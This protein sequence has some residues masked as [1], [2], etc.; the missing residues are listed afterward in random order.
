MHNVSCYLY[1]CEGYALHGTELSPRL[2]FLRTGPFFALFILWFQQ[3]CLKIVFILRQNRTER[4]KRSF[5]NGCLFNYFKLYIL[6]FKIRL[7]Q[8]VAS[9]YN[10][11]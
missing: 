11:L 6:G 5:F 7:D 8:I 4:F 2:H 9:S 3:N 10:I 1:C